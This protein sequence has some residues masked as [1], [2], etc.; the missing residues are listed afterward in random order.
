MRTMFSIFIFL[1][2]SV[3]VGIVAAE[4]IDIG[5]RRELFVEQTLIERLD[6]RAELR[7]HHPTPRE[8]AITFEKPWEGNAVTVHTPALPETQELANIK[9]KLEK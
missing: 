5:S 7:L 2:I 3:P 8:V 6:G 9:N 4:T 1:A